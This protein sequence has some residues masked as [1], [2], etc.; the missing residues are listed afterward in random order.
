MKLLKNNIMQE[1]KQKKSLVLKKMVVAMLTTVNV[2]NW[3]VPT[4]T[5]PS[6]V[7]TCKDVHNNREEA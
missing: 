6:Y 5:R 4:T 1:K 7:P 3:I 2:N